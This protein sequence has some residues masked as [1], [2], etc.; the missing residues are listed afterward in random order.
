M[1]EKWNKVRYKLEVFGVARHDPGWIYI[2]KNGDLL[3]V[4]KT[5]DPRQ[6]VKEAR[7]W[8]PNINILG[9]K[10]FWNV[11][12]IEQTLHEGCAPYWYAGEWFKFDFPNDC[13]LL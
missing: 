12:H 4:G 1:A 6:R 9:I 5:T 13:E 3:K 2:F 8:L 7:T 10:P 11:S